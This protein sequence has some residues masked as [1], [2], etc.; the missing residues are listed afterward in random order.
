MDSKFIGH[1]DNR[2][3]HERPDVSDAIEHGILLRLMLRGRLRRPDES[4]A[5]GR[6]RR[7]MVVLLIRMY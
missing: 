2:G 3:F 6:L 5:G 1:R 4:R 7:P